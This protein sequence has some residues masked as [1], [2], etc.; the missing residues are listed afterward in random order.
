[1]RKINAKNK[2]EG[3]FKRMP[4]FFVI[5]SLQIYMKFA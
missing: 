5:L 3:Q 4:L 1:M 2:K